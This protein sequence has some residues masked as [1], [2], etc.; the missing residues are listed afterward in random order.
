MA[1]RPRF[2]RILRTFIDHGIDIVFEA[3]S[4]KS[5]PETKMPP[6]LRPYEEEATRLLAEAEATAE[7][8]GAVPKPVE[9]ETAWTPEYCLEC[10]DRHIGIIRDALSDVE[11][12]TLAGESRE[13]IMEKVADFNEA[14]AGM[15][16]DLKKGL[17]EPLIG[18]FYEDQRTL[19]KL[20][21]D[22]RFGAEPTAEKARTLKAEADRL[23]AKLYEI[24]PK[25]PG[26][27]IFRW[28][29]EWGCKD[30]GEGVRLWLSAQE[31]AVGREEFER[32]FHELT[33]KRC[34]TEWDERGR[35]KGL[36]LV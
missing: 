15:E 31:G 28:M 11:R 24:A 34:R 23:L 6:E 1:R 4:P 17:A 7:S 33:G 27:G 29:K 3:F 16:S 22:M 10:C 32:R 36:K 13:K 20:A 30:I 25:V 14:M 8:V 19:R 35:I 9:G 18:E 2:S 26:G 21:W 5:K 12:W